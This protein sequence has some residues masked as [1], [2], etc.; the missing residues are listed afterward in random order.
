[1][2]SLRIGAADLHLLTD[3]F[4]ELDGDRVFFPAQRKQWNENLQVLSGK[5][6]A[7]V[8]GLLVRKGSECVLVDTGYG[9]N[10][11]REG[12]Q[13]IARKLADLGVT[14][15]QITQVIITHAH[16]DHCMG[17]TTECH[18]EWSATY[19]RAAYY[20]EERE[21]AGLRKADDPLW[22]TS[23]EP[24]LTQGRLHLTT[25]DA[26]ITDTVA[27]WSTPGH[28]IGHQSVLVESEDASALF[29]GDLAIVAANMEHPEWGP[30]W[31]WSCDADRESR[32]KIAEWAVHTN[33]MLVIGHDPTTPWI[34]LRAHRD[35]F[36]ALVAVRAEDGD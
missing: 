13:G 35:R 24:L 15:D 1:M 7:A 31:A 17:N 3:A 34:Q 8:R 23:F 27:C 6:Q 18:N 21:I 5:V 11:P 14:P 2:Q 9:T 32:R 25:P 29:V 4:I 30:E 36:K 10:H 22:R 12:S 20:I 19:P 28:T 33:A 16:G 26:R